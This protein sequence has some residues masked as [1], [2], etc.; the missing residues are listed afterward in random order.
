MET[1]ALSSYGRQGKQK[2]RKGPILREEAVN[3]RGIAE[4]RSLPSAQ[5][6]G[7]PREDQGNGLMEKVVTWENMRAALRRV[8]QSKG[9]GGIDGVQVDE[10]RDLVREVWPQVREKLLSG[11]YQPRPVRRVEIPPNVKYAECF[12]TYQREARE[13]NAGL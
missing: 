3:M 8:E 12:R 6:G 7:T 4:G 9:A 5:V 11:T 10:F 2:T 13:K 1:G